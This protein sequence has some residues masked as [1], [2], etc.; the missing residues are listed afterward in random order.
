[1]QHN[2]NPGLTH[3]NQQHGKAEHGA[4]TSTKFAKTAGEARTH[5]A[6]LDVDN[7]LATCEAVLRGY[8]RPKGTGAGYLSVCN[9]RLSELF[10]DRKWLWEPH[11]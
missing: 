1:M 11:D 2:S 7:P 8:R 4:S 3:H 10:E 6:E 9:V 5:K